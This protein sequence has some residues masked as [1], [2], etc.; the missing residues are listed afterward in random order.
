MKESFDWDKT[1]EFRG[2]SH[3]SGYEKTEIPT[4]LTY[5]EVLIA[6]GT[7]MLTIS[8]TSLVH[9]EFNYTLYGNSPVFCVRDFDFNSILR[10][11]VS[12]GVIEFKGTKKVFLTEK[13]REFLCENETIGINFFEKKR[14]EAQKII[15]SVRS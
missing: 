13:G 7:L 6:L 14:E 3:W 9:H 12:Q 5:R 2:Y 11:L 15:E 1:I 10:T 4:A 8:N